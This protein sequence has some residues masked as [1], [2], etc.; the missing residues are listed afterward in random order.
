MSTTESTSAYISQHSGMAA[1][2]TEHV[3][4]NCW[5]VCVGEGINSLTWPAMPKAVLR[6]VL[7]VYFFSGM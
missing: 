6:K 5:L 7:S 2:Q 3:A 1:R 4:F